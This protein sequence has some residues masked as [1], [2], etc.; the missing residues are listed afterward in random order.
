MPTQKTQ[1]RI[2]GMMCSFCSQT[3]EKGLMRTRGVKKV[4][5]SLAHQE[6]LIEHDP[7]EIQPGEIKRILRGLGYIVRDPRKIQNFEEEDRILKRELH[8]MIFGWSFAIGATGFMVLNWLDVS[9]PYQKW[10]MFT[11]A[12]ITVF[13]G[14]AHIVEMSFMAL[15]RWIFNQ[16]VLL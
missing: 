14:G 11:M 10:I 15:R 4:N 13:G 7:E 8:R 6:A 9:I 3:I 12:T 1:L 2:G 5:V 16:H